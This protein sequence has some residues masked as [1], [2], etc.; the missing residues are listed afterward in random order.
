VEPDNNMDELS[1]QLNLHFDRTRIWK[2]GRVYLIK[3]LVATVN[4]LKIVVYR[5][6]YPP[7]FHVLSKQRSIDARFSLDTL[8]YINEKGNKRK[9]KSDDIKKI[10]AFFEWRPDKLKLLR[11]RHARLN[12][13]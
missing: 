5:D 6:H 13:D 12:I 7:H 2:D 8:D 11:D 3:E 9:I 1:E 4:D 10:K